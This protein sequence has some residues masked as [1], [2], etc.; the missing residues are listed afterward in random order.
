M[1]CEQSKRQHVTTPVHPL[2]RLQ[3]SIGNRAVARLIQV[4]LQ[5]KEAGSEYGEQP[6]KPTSQPQKG[7]K[8]ELEFHSALHFNS[9]FSGFNPTAEPEEGGYGILWWS[10]WNTGWTRAPEHTN[11]LTI[12]NAALCSG[13]RKQEDEISRHEIPGPS[14]VSGV[15]QG[16]S[17]YENAVVVGPFAAGRYEA[18]VELDVQKQV[19]EI[20]ENNNT[21]FLNFNIKPGKD[22]ESAFEGTV[23]RK[24]NARHGDVP[25]QAVRGDLIQRQPESGP[26][27][28]DVPILLEKLEL[29]VGNNLLDYGHHLY[30]A[31]I[32]YRD[33][34]EA[35]KEALGRYALGANVLKD[36]YRFL[37]FRPDT[38][39]KLA[40]GTGILTKGVTLLRSG[41]LILDFQFDVGRGVKFETNLNLGV[42]PKDLTDVRKAEVQF[43]LV[44]RF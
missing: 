33:D 16:K 39:G 3:Q 15:E 21:A 18:F 29:D 44:R 24:G 28:R 13:C 31:A 8:A 32:L 41:E 10:V 25:V 5:K 22:S 1:I 6:H 14:I 30:R 23:Q 37:G 43:G 17:E 35:L 19:D 7:T 11:R 26:S 20:N 40:V 42:N 9:T 34:P 4:K 27:V 2:L 12:Y 36:T 38:A